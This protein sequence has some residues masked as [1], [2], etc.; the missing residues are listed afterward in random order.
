MEIRININTFRYL[1]CLCAFVLRGRPQALVEYLR[2]YL[3]PMYVEWTS[4]YLIYTINCDRITIISLYEIVGMMVYDEE[5]C[6][7]SQA[8]FCINPLSAKFEFNKLN[9]FNVIYYYYYINYN[10]IIYQLSF[11]IGL[12]YQHS[13]DGYQQPYYLN[14]A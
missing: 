12:Y 11:K 8:K 13:V 4:P 5:H 14:G 6:F 3:I 7:L 9:C 1:Y 10:I 2:S